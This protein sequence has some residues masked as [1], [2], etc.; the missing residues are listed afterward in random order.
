MRVAAA[1]ASVEFCGHVPMTPAAFLADMLVPLKSL[2]ADS[3]QHVRCALA[4]K[5]LQLTPQCTLDD[6]STHMLDLILTLL[7]DKVRP[8]LHAVP[9]SDASRSFSLSRLPH[10][11][12]HAYQ[13]SKKRSCI[14]AHGAKCARMR[15]QVPEV[16]LNIIQSLHH[17][18]E[19]LSNERL[20]TSV[21]PAIDELSSDPHWR[22][23]HAVITQL[24]LLARQLGLEF[25]EGKLLARNREWLRDPVATIREAAIKVRSHCKSN[26]APAIAC[27]RAH[28]RFPHAL[29]SSILFP[30]VCVPG[31]SLR[32]IWTNRTIRFRAFAVPTCRFA[33]TRLWEACHVSLWVLRPV[34][35]GAV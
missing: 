34:V 15:M 27:S 7:K 28:A 11:C 32:C 21:V 10:S 17:A 33:M 31:G 20:R 4:S 14:E 19:V 16:R 13:V 2:A 1:E 8:G 23:R 22:V 25:Y 9:I 3:H 18:K 5:A 24:P 12:R 35:E 26:T 30:V 29:S 6:S